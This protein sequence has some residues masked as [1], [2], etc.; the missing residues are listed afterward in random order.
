MDEFVDPGPSEGANADIGIVTSPQISLRRDTKVRSAIEIRPRG[1]VVGDRDQQVGFRLQ[2]TGERNGLRFDVV[3]GLM[4]SWG[5]MPSDD[6]SGAV[7]VAGDPVA[8]GSGGI[9]G[10]H[11]IPT[12]Q[13]IEQGALARVR[14]SEDDHSRRSQQMVQPL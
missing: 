4:A 11:P 7:D 2:T 12:Q 14:C 3:I 10:D 6:Q 1:F 8:C 9:M 13:C 5:V